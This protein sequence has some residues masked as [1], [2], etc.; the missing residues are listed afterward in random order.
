[1]TTGAGALFANLTVRTPSD[2]HTATP[3]QTTNFA[4][5]ESGLSDAALNVGTFGVGLA[6][7]DSAVAYR[8][9]IGAAKAPTL[10]KIDLATGASTELAAPDLTGSSTADVWGL[11]DRAWLLTSDF[12][13]PSTG[14][15]TLRPFDGSADVVF[16]PT[17]LVDVEA[18]GSAGVLYLG[19][20]LVPD[21]VHTGQTLKD[22][23]LRL[24]SPDLSTT[25]DVTDFGTGFDPRASLLTSMDRGAIA[26]WRQD[27]SELGYRELGQ[28]PHLVTF[29][30]QP[31]DS[32]TLSVIPGAIAIVSA[33]PYE[34]WQWVP[35]VGA[36]VASATLFVNVMSPW[37]TTQGTPAFSSDSVI[38]AD[39]D[40]DWVSWLPGAATGTPL[41]S[42]SPVYGVTVNAVGT[43]SQLGYQAVLGSDS[44]IDSYIRSVGSTSTSVVVH[45][46]NALYQTSPPAPYLGGQAIAL[47][48]SRSVVLHENADGSE[49]LIL[50]NGTKVTHR[51]KVGPDLI[52]FAISGP[53]VAYSSVKS[54]SKVI[55]P[56]GS[57]VITLP[58]GL[59][60][61]AQDGNSTAY[62]TQDGSIYVRD[63]YAPISKT[64]PRKV[65]NKC[66]AIANSFCRMQLQFSA[67]YVLATDIT[68]NRFIYKAYDIAHK[69]QRTLPNA[70][71]DVNGTTVLL[72]ELGRD[73]LP[74]TLHISTLDLA[75]KSAAPIAV[76]DSQI[77][78]PG[79]VFAGHKLVWAT[80][81]DAV[82]A[83]RSETLS[84]APL[85]A[86]ADSIG[87][88]RLRG[89]WSAHGQTLSLKSGAWSPQ[90]AVSDQLTSWTLT[91]RNSHGAVVRV[92]HGTTKDGS[93]N[94]V[95]WNGRGPNGRE[96]AIGKYTW[97]LTGT[98]PYGG[99]L[100]TSGSG[101]A[102]GRVV[103]TP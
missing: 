69:T 60:A 71:A 6:T 70:Y 29:A 96:V 83:T 84:I 19:Y 42:R 43:N 40:V 61:V 36:P 77:T 3:V 28:S 38:D 81:T 25:V 80:S 58:K 26:W 76:V 98:G 62:M 95:S 72:R 51:V 30:M 8:A 68:S 4:D 91:M 64:N 39:L 78:D 50:R 79:P 97:T 22:Y 5:L 31:A 55:G 86:A 13:D 74:S 92:W 93:I 94:G 57:T 44:G 24:T 17:D 67:G 32:L 90:M 49:W 75:K 33:N 21:P 10:V 14:T 99:P 48:G 54:G 20:N 18:A 102:S 12:F 45:D 53:L 15:Y 65:V 59:R 56:D 23:V 27:N 66:A 82:A 16:R 88:P 2:P 63:D 87:H 11:T 47:S 103:V 1:V 37:S 34:S 52:D 41:V 89:V 85:P 46:P 7:S 101:A 9:F 100:A 73:P 35:G